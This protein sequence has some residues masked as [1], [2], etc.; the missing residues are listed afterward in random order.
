MQLLASP[1][2][3]CVIVLCFYY[4]FEYCNNLVLIDAT[5]SNSDL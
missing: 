5:M 3:V 4:C 2:Y 1:L